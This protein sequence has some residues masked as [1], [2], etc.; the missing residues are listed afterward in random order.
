MWNIRSMMV[1]AAIAI[2]AFTTPAMAAA[3]AAK[4]V[5][6]YV[7]EVARPGAVTY[8]Y[9][10]VNGGRAA[11]TALVIGYSFADGIPQLSV[12]SGWSRKAVPASSS[13]SP[14]GWTFDI[15]R[16]PKES[17]FNLEWVSEGQTPGIRGRTTRDGF[18]VTIPK[19]DPRYA[20]GKWMVILGSGQRTHFE[21]NLIPESR[22]GAPARSA[23]PLASR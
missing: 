12:P 1:A 2:P 6:V 23:G 13:R 19:R 21:G 8:R 4:P 11:I 10:V 20:Q 17:H 22:P 18:E 15:F 5:R 3:R 16:T 9:R 7:H 14:R